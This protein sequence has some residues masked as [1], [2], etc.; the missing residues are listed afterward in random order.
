M[1]AAIRDSPLHPWGK[2]E[3]AFVASGTYQE[4]VELYDIV[5]GKGIWP[6]AD[7]VE[8]QRKREERA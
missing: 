4:M 6:K 7:V 5:K 8:W 2:D 1:I 3:F